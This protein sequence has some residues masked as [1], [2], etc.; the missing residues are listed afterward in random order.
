MAGKISW[1]PFNERYQQHTMA[2]LSQCQRYTRFHHP[3]G[4]E[5]VYTGG[6]EVTASIYLSVA[7]IYSAKQRKPCDFLAIFG[8]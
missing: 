7:F 6:T 4:G 8:K 1:S 3:K 2:E 5:V